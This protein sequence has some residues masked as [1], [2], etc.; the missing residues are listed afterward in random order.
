MIERLIRLFRPK[1]ILRPRLH[2]PDYI[3]RHAGRPFLVLGSGPSIRTHADTIDQFVQDRNPVVLTANVPHPLWGASMNRI[4]YVGFTNRRRLG[5]ARIFP[6]LQS[7]P[8]LIGP[9]IHTRQIWMPTWERMPFVADPDAAFDI[10]DGIVQ[11][12]CH[13]CGWLLVAVAWVMGASE[14]WM[15]GVDGYSREGPNHFYEQGDYKIALSLARQARIQSEL[16][17]QMRRCFEGTNVRGPLFLTPTIY[18]PVEAE[19]ARVSG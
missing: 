3:G 2:R 15:A 1:K 18:G 6:S 17:P 5:Q 9:H 11:C 4:Q 12:S 7:T 19:Y 8:C 13:E 16:L 10:V 14:I